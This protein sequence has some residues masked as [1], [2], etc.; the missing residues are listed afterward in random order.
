MFDKSLPANQHFPKVSV[1]RDFPS[2]MKQ[3]ITTNSTM[4][5]DSAPQSQSMNTIAKD[6]IFSHFG[7]RIALY[8]ETTAPRPII[9]RRPRSPF[10]RA[11]PFYSSR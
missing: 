7:K 10:M 5:Q 1:T 3:P 11:F 6:F 2:A 8:R 9:I 4:S